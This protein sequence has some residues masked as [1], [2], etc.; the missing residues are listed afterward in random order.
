MYC[1][2]QDVRNRNKI[3][4]AENVISDS[5]IESKINNIESMVN[6]MLANRYPVPLTTVPDV[7]REITADMTASKLI[8]QKVG[9]EGTDEEPVQAE[10]LWKEAMVLL[11]LIN[12]GDMQLTLP[13]QE[14]KNNTTI[15]STTYGETPVFLDWDPTDYASYI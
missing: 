8:S 2:V 4:L 13:T 6:G 9:N 14:V 5:D 1:S 7:I 12:R 15:I 10:N 3:I 11:K